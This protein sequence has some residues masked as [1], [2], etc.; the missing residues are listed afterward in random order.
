MRL[1][2][3]HSSTLSAFEYTCKNS[4][5]GQLCKRISLCPINEI[6]GLYVIAMIETD[7]KMNW[8]IVSCVHSHG[9]G[10]TMN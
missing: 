6:S 3:L 1:D 8:I 7:G 2:Y 9:A 10:M 5:A 4:S